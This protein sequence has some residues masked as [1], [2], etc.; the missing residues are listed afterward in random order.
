MDYDRKDI[1]ELGKFVREHIRSGDNANLG[2]I[3]KR[4]RSK[5]KEGLKATDAEMVCILLE[6]IV[7]RW[8]WDEKQ[9][10]RSLNS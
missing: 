9:D 3:V 5:Q 2:D 7:T 4:I 6:D 10:S 1:Y 8:W